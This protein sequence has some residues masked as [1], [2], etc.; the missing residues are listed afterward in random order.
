LSRRTV[1][2]AP[3]EFAFFLENEHS[4]ME[5]MQNPPTPTAGRRHTLKVKTLKRKL[6][7]AG[8]KTTGR[9]A[10]LLK[11]AKKAHIKLGGALSP[12]PLAGG[13]HRR[14]RRGGA[15]EGAE[16]AK[17][18]ES[19]SDMGAPPKGGRRRRSRKFLGVF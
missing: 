2:L 16:G 6:K 11:R 13:R 8:V 15:H 10:T 1:F 19:G 3:R 9:K 4:N 14:S 12:L 7:A 18:A 5:P 17:G